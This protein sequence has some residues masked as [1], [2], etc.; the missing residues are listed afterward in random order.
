MTIVALLAAGQA[1]WESPL[2]RDALQ[3]EGIALARRCVDVADAV[4]TAASGEVQVALLSMDLPGLDTDVVARIGETGVHPIGIVSGEE[5]E[6]ARAVALGMRAVIGVDDL[7]GLAG[8]VADLEQGAAGPDRAAVAHGRNGTS[9]EVA[10]PGQVVAVWGPTGAPGRSTVALG[11]ASET[12][13]HGVPTLLL[14]ADVYGGS[15]AQMLA[16]LDEVSGL[17]AACR[18]ADTGRLDAD[19]LRRHVLRIDPML[20]LLTGLPRADRWAGLREASFSAVLEVARE[21]ASVVV[22]DLGFC[23]ETPE[24][25]TFDTAAPRRNGVTLRALEQADV[26]TVVGS[27]DPLGLTRLT[28]AVFDLREA[29]PS[30]DP[31][32]VV[33]KVRRSLGWRDDEVVDTVRRFTGLTPTRLLPLDQEATDAA[34]TDGRTLGE[35]ARGSALHGELSTLA[36]VLTVADYPAPRKARGRRRR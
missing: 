9:A 27:A 31:R 15:V 25:L 2:V 22:V 21:L 10:R 1:P 6:D 34:W 30:A 3:T 14:D 11:V 36:K 32:V 35:C 19:G 33:N 13:A 12:A 23:L 20:G 26:T 28:R 29:V 7:G 24:A 17:L 18:S 8:V 16:I 4:A 5:G